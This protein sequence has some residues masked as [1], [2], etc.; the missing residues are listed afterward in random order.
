[1]HSLVIKTNERQRLAKQRAAQFRRGAVF[2][3]ASEEGAKARKGGK[4]GAA[5]ED[6]RIVQDPDVYVTAT[7]T[8]L[9]P[10]NVAEAA[11]VFLSNTMGD[12]AEAV[13]AAEEQDDA[14]KKRGKAKAPE[15]LAREARLVRYKQ[16][17]AD[18]FVASAMNKD[19]VTELFVKTYA[20]EPVPYVPTSSAMAPSLRW[21]KTTDPDIRVFIDATKRLVVKMYPLDTILASF[22]PASA[23]VSD[24]K[25]RDLPSIVDLA[26]DI[27]V[28]YYLT[29][30]V[31][32]YERVVT[33][34]FAYPVDWFIGPKIDADGV[35]FERNK[36]T[37]NLTVTNVRTLDKTLAQYVVVERA[38]MTLGALLESPSLSVCQLRSLI[39]QIFFSLEAAWKLTGYLHYDAHSG[40]FMVRNLLTELDSPYLNR[41]WAY[42]RPGV[43]S[44]SYLTLADHGHLFIEI[45][46]AGRSRMFVS[47]D[48]DVVDPAT[49][50]RPLHLIGYSVRKEYGIIVEETRDERVDRSWDV[51]RMGIDLLETVNVDKLVARQQEGTV[52]SALRDQEEARLGLL[53]AHLIGTMIGGRRFAE[54]VK[55]CSATITYAEDLR[56]KIVRKPEERAQLEAKA[57]MWAA[58]VTS[59]DAILGDAS[60]TPATI[61]RVF[62][63]AIG[64]EIARAGDYK[65]LYYETVVSDL[66]FNHIVDPSTVGLYRDEALH[67]SSCLDHALFERLRGPLD[68]SQ[69]MVL[70]ANALV[71]GFATKKDMLT[72]PVRGLYA[73]PVGAIEENTVSP[74]GEE[75]GSEE[76]EPDASKTA[77]KAAGRKKVERA[78]KAIITKERSRR[79]MTAKPGEK[80]K[81]VYAA[82]ASCGEE[83]MGLALPE[84]VPYCG[85]DCVWHATNDM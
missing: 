71:V 22:I 39:F 17:L 44:Y 9:S 4:G 13:P 57:S 73:A 53:L 58:L 74:D 23:S 15:T 14:V 42:K 24:D 47:R 81:D 79:N 7:G 52:D 30:L 8:D 27:C 68:E 43:A 75:E 59:A 55:K 56:L 2:R 80:T 37:Q 26:N 20:L 65:E 19:A 66:L 76:L 41:S 83:A 21:A 38:D 60:A 28:S 16:R 11:F 67:V 54:A 78:S 5:A 18:M 32:D 62:S 25:K 45:I 10:E 63:A 72:D 33:P 6:V 69:R 1:M 34:H 31:R 77:S 35:V 51:R 46:D 84:R 29:S 85:L 12:A 3:K 70:Q 48:T 50:K 61:Y 49:K 36:E 82:C 40:N 64:K